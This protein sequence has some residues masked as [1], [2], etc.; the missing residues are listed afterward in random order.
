LNAKV[1]FTKVFFTC[2]TNEYALLIFNLVCI[3]D[4]ET[5]G[6][7]N[8]ADA[9]ASYGKQNELSTAIIHSVFGIVSYRN[10]MQFLNLQM[11]ILH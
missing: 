11:I 7:H 3:K 6:N 8:D 1:F 10:L 9:D 4:L 5:A 2:H